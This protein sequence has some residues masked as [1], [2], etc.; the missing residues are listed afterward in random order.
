MN[1]IRKVLLGACML[2]VTF[3][4]TACNQQ[5]FDTT[6]KFDKVIICMP[7]GTMVQGTV[8]SWKEYDDS[9][10]IQIKVDGTYYYTHLQNVLLIAD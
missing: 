3:A 2:A 4:T 5:M 8:E 6:Y 9:D 10:A 1:Y 7:D